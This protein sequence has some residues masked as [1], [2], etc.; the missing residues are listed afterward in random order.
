VRFAA[1]QARDC[2]SPVDVVTLLS[3]LPISYVDRHTANVGEAAIDSDPK[4]WAWCTNP[5]CQ[6]IIH[7]RGPRLTGKTNDTIRYA[8]ITC[9]QKMTDS[10]L[11]LSHE[12]RNLKN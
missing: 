3:I 2:S 8:S 4:N 6:K 12:F 10:Q 7:R 9:N 1:V 5:K 11:S